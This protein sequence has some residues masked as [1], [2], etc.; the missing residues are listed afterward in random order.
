[1]K[2]EFMKKIFTLI[3]AL[4]L[5]IPAM[6][7]SPNGFSYQAMARDNT[8]KELKNT[9]VSLRI[10]LIQSS[11]TGT[12]LYQETHSVTSNE[13]GLLNLTIGAGSVVTGQFSAIDWSD[14]TKY[15]KVELDASGGTSYQLMGTTQ[16]LSVPFAL[17]ANSTDQEYSLEDLQN[18]STTGAN[19]KDVLQFNGTSWQP[20]T[21]S[22]SSIGKLADLSDVSTTSAKSD[23]ILKYNGSTWAPATLPTSSVSDLDDLGDVSASSPKSDEFLKY[24]G[25][26]WVPSA[27]P[28][29][30]I[31]DLSDVKLSNTSSKDLLQ[32][33]G[34]TWVND[35]YS[36]ADLT[37]TRISTTPK[38]NDVLQWNGSNWAPA[39]ISGGSGGLGGS[40]TQY[41]VPKFRT[42]TS[43]QISKIYDNDTS[44]AIGTTTPLNTRE[45]VVETNKPVAGFMKTNYTNA[46]NPQI[47]RVEYDGTTRFNPT[48][49]QGVA[50][51][52]GG[53]GWGGRFFGGSAGVIAVVAPDTNTTSFIT[54][55]YSLVDGNNLI[56]ER[57]GSFART[58]TGNR[59]WG[60]YGLTNTAD[61]SGQLKIGVMGI[62]PNAYDPSK[63]YYAGYFIGDVGISGTISKSSGTFKIDHP[64]DPE[65]KFLYH[66]FVE[67]PDMLNI[68]SGT[69]TTDANGNAVVELPDYFEALNKDFTYQLTVIGSF[70]RAIVAEEVSDNQFAIKTDEPNV[71]VSW[72]VTGVRDDAYAQKNRVKPEVAKNEMERGKYLHPEVFGK[73][74]DLKINYGVNPN[75]IDK[76][77][78]NSAAPEQKK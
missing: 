48:A 61:T 29:K 71:K 47:L 60:V 7:Q 57:I 62:S 40:G 38:Q 13:F 45:F 34:N 69:T 77:M 49:V 64:L 21:V 78:T 10:S 50:Q 6:A 3:L 33:N 17:H 27:L 2:I 42:S 76:E 1:F 18:V 35:G 4:C 12:I 5:F 39:A 53:F 70:A 8:G 16:L 32:W 30:A 41:Y 52:V 23:D 74:Q 19:D 56:G 9:K 68:Y 73:S 46:I 24:N 11:P 66:S 54:G 37:D 58:N 75:K 15:V 43:L 28:T 25:T 31:G 22:S 63:I 51:P 36:L 72:M 55:S 59:Q 26:S 44:V 14:G 65:N 67:S 20:G